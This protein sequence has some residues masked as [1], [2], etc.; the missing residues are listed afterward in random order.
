MLTV[1]RSKILFLNDILFI[2]LNKVYLN[3]GIL[4][5]F[6]NYIKEIISYG[7]VN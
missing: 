2:L 6:E 7:K 5:S 4:C 3:I 1:I